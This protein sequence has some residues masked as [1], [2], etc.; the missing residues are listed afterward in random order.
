MNVTNGVLTAT[1]NAG[2]YGSPINQ[3][4]RMRTYVIPEFKTV[5]RVSRSGL[6]MWSVVDLGKE[7]IVLSNPYTNGRYF[8][9][10]MMNMWTDDYGSVG[11]R[12]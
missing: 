9:M 1:P 5:V 10:Q 12:T 3:F 7:P 2:Q 6:W 8:G 11:S 4:G